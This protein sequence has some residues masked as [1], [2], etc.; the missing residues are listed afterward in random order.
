MRHEGV[1]PTEALC[2]MVLMAVLRRIR[3]GVNSKQGLAGAS[4]WVPKAVQ[5]RRTTTRNR[6]QSEDCIYL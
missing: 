4:V 3:A 6:N 1:V 5:V 2:D